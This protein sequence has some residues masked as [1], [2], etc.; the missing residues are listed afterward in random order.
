MGMDSKAELNHFTPETSASGV[1][2]QSTVDNPSSIDGLPAEMLMQSISESVKVDTARS[3]LKRTRPKKL[4]AV[5]DRPVVNGDDH[6]YLNENTPRFEGDIYLVGNSLPPVHSGVQELP[7]QLPGRGHSIMSYAAKAKLIGL[8]K[9]QEII[10]NKHCD[11][12]FDSIGRHKRDLAWMSIAEEMQLN[13]VDSL[14]ACWKRMSTYCKEMEQI[15]Q[16][17]NRE[18][19]WDLWEHLQFLRCPSAL[20]TKPKCSN[21]RPPEK[22]ARLNFSQRKKL[23][24]AIKCQPAI[25]DVVNC[26]GY[27]DDRKDHAW[28]T[29]GDVVSLS[30]SPE[31][32]LHL[33]ICCHQ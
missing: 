12:F 17:Q 24:K 2:S 5:S 33:K 29:V 13:D 31:S 15:K 14:K 11:H 26:A 1:S 10:W 27:H 28:E 18:P 25:W 20:K 19:V 16:K 21:E 9:Q 6:D 7:L 8:V 23:I 3:T 4:S 30:G 22:L 32:N